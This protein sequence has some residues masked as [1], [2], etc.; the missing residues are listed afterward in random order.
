MLILLLLLPSI[1]SVY[2]T[3]CN[4]R[5]QLN[6]ITDNCICASPYYGLDCSLKRCPSGVPWMPILFNSS[7]ST[8]FNPGGR[9]ECSYMGICDSSTGICI[10]RKG[11]EG[12]AC[13]RMA[14][15][16]ELFNYASNNVNRLPTK[17]A[18]C[19]DHG[20]C[21]YSSEVISLLNPSM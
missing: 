8:S 7:K 9:V 17:S 10:C 3:D 13:E 21:Y 5:G 11:Y 1:P 20:R 6:I 14:C 16:S 12:R 15:P 2:S 4:G 18:T 19:S